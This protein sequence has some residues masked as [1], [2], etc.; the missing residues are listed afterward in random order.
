MEKTYYKNG[1]IK[2]EYC[3]ND[4]G[5]Y[6]GILK[7]YY[8]NGSLKHK[9]VFKNG[10]QQGEVVSYYHTGLKEAIA[11]IVDGDFEGLVEEW[12]PNGNLKHRLN[13]KNDNPT[14]DIKEWDYFGKKITDQ[15][16]SDFIP[17]GVDVG[18]KVNYRILKKKFNPELVFAEFYSDLKGSDWSSVLKTEFQIKKKFES[19]VLAEKFYSEFVEKYLFKVSTVNDNWVLCKRDGF[20]LVKIKHLNLIILSS[21]QYFN[22][23]EIMNPGDD[24]DSKE[25]ISPN[26][27]QGIGLICKEH[28]NPKLYIPYFRIDSSNSENIQINCV[29]RLIAEYIADQVVLKNG[30][31]DSFRTLQHLDL[32]RDDKYAYAGPLFVIYV[33]ENRSVVINR[34]ES[35]IKRVDGKKS[36]TGISSL[37][38]QI[39]K[40]ISGLRILIY[41]EGDGMVQDGRFWINENHSIINSW[42]QDKNN[43]I[44]KFK[45]IIKE[46]DPSHSVLEF[47][48]KS[49]MKKL[50]N[51]DFLEGMSLFHIK[52]SEKYFVDISIGNNF[53]HITI[54]INT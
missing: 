11:N 21:L 23:N 10:V 41:N 27:I 6:N 50:N 44:N 8:P 24:V 36:E 20:E 46:H 26:W 17:S 31:F 32:W 13:Y 38:D 39:N 16:V 54:I 1:N 52:I 35:S 49:L 42:F 19:E 12:W 25:F 45:E 9:S 30:G 15:K 18:N 7:K 14:G 34:V 3:L 40:D 43:A 5:E 47:S 28:D 2:E 22:K 33:N 48:N 29:T 37:S 51:N 4:K 53:T